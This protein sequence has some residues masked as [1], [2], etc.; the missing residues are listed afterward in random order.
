MVKLVRVKYII[1]YFI[2][3]HLMLVLEINAGMGDL[4]VDR[5]LKNWYNKLLVEGAI[6]YTIVYLRTTNVAPVGYNVVTVGDGL[7]MM[8]GSVS[9]PKSN[10]RIH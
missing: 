5:M 4:G 8:T 7:R 6:V 2:C 1:V 3:Q 10:I 9:C